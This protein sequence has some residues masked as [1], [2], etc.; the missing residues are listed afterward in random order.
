MSSVGADLVSKAGE[1]CSPAHYGRE[2]EESSPRCVAERSSGRT[3]RCRDAPR[4]LVERF[5]LALRACAAPQTVL[6]CHPV[7][8]LM[9][10]IRL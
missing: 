5:V 2:C 10:V 6:S 9:T 7:P 4:T 1:K 8:S 3:F